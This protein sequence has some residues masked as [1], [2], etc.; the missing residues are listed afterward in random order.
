MGTK[1]SL[2]ILGALCLVS[3]LIIGKT[4]ASISKLAELS[5]SGA[6]GAQVLNIHWEDNTVEIL[7]YDY[8]DDAHETICRVPMLETY[9]IKDLPAVQLVGRTQIDDREIIASLDHPDQQRGE[10]LERLEGHT[11][12]FQEPWDLRPSGLSINGVIT[13]SRRLPAEIQ[14]GPKHLFFEVSIGLDTNNETTLLQGYGFVRRVYG[15]VT[16]KNVKLITV[17]VMSCGMVCSGNLVLF[18]IE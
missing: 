9:N 15:S 17:D 13:Y 4:E 10:L 14:T 8:C 7:V 12:T 5:Y 6:G 18:K 1:V 3:V 16:Q 2:Q 11:I